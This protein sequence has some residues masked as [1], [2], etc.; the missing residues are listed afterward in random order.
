MEVLGPLVHVEG[1]WGGTITVLGILAL[2]ELDAG[3]GVEGV[4]GGAVGWAVHGGAVVIAMAKH[5]W[6][7]YSCGKTVLK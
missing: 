7:G 5:H 3:R 2:R 4:G 1:V 6:E